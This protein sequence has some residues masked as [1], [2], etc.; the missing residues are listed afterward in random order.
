MPMARTQTLVQ[1]SD[2]LLQRLD[3]YR[4]REGRSRSEVIRDAVERYLAEDRETE[5]DRL[6]VD[7]YSR[8]PQDDAWSEQAARWMI[9][10]E[11][12]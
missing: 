12:W 1:F 6:I 10:S 2:D 3:R 9:A 7:A 11:P 4:T 8:Q 5:I